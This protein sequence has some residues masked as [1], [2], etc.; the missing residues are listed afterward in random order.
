MC[1]CVHAEQNALLQAARLGYTSDGAVCSTTLRPCFGCLKELHQGGIA[2]V[3]FLNAWAPT[4]PPL[5]EAY[6][7]LL[8]QL[9]TR[10]VSV[11]ELALDQELLDLR[12]RP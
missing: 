1:I 3:R 8:A 4:P 9:A 12:G 2:S 10:G 5:R 7:D 11:E 6:D